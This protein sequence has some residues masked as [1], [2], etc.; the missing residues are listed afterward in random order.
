MS[1]RAGSM[2]SPITRTRKTCPM[3]LG[4]PVKYIDHQVVEAGADL[5]GADNPH[6]RGSST[7]NSPSKPSPSPSRTQLTPTESVGH[8]PPRLPQELAEMV[9]DELGRDYQRPALA[10]CSLTC[11]AWLH[12]CR[13]HIHSAVRLDPQS[14]L[15]NLSKLYDGP[16]AEYVRSL[17]IDA[18]VEGE[19]RPHPWLNTVR[20][21][22]ERLKR[23]R[24]LALDAIVWE[25]L[26][27]ATK[28]IFLTNYEDVRDIWLATCDFYDPA[29]FV[30][31]LQVFKRAESIRMEG[32]GC[33]PVDCE[34]A[35]KEN[36]EEL[37]LR[38]LDV[39]DL[40]SAPS[41]VAQWAWYGRRELSL[42]NI[43]FS[44]GSE[45]PIHLSRMLQLAGASVQKLSITMDDHVQRA[46][47]T[48]GE[49]SMWFTSRPR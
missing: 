37:H 6:P 17:S 18:C 23:I 12:R 11:R 9:I 40:C 24:R 1:G 26:E 28:R 16:L 49:S 30:R 21:L 7:S 41:I 20:P 31:F 36:D 22:L 14:H 43:H 29:T 19:P 35:L 46:R 44:W 34:E 39:G 8:M 47:T 3:T 15:E 48:A 38:W 5:G 27:D 2:G 45:D 13:I 32:V 4:V 10:A 25:H 33:D 42:E